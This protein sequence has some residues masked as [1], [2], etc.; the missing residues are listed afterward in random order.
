MED[1][2]KDVDA[3][4]E[5]YRRRLRAERKIAESDLDELEDHLRELTNQLLTEGKPAAEAVTEAAR[6]LG[7]PRQLARELAR[8]RSPFGVPL[9]P[10]RAL[11]G[12]VLFVLPFIRVLAEYYTR[13][14]LAVGDIPFRFWFVLAVFVVLA[15]ALATRMTWARAVVL[16][17]TMQTLT[18]YLG[19]PYG[20]DP[21]GWITRLGGLALVM[22]WRRTEYSLAAINL[23]LQAWA[24]GSAWIAL[25][26]QLAPSDA[27]L[28]RSVCGTIALVCAAA[29]CIGTVRGARWSA[30]TSAVSALALFIALGALSTAQFHRGDALE[31]QVH[32]F[33]AVGSGAI[34]ATVAAVLGWRTTRS[35]VGPL[36][37]A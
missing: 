6:R 14:G 21:F 18:I 24:C 11:I 30:I 5:E 20:A 4:I 36:Q 3:E 31:W 7:D 17:V 26:S 8:V 34:A 32:V 33:G 9:S 22:P 2:V 27:V 37:R 12:A 29:G 10:G 25:A 16:G 1:L 13:P 28:L 19:M 35:L 15:V 23:A